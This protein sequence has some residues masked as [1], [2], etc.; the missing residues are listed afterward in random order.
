[1]QQ[2]LLVEDSMMFGRLAK[3][4]LEKVFDIPV[5]WAQSLAETEKLLAQANGNFS[6][7]LLDFNLPDAPQGE[8]IDMVVDHGISAI[9]FTTNM[10][11]EV[12]TRIWDKKVADYIIKE[13]PNSLDYVISTIRQFEMNQNTLVLIVDKSDSNRSYF[14][15]LLYVRKF[16]V[17]NASDAETAFDILQ[18]YPE[19]KLVIA[20]FETSGFDGCSFSQKIRE[21]HTQEELAI[22]GFTP[23]DD[24]M[25]GIAYIKSGASDYVITDPFIVEEFY[26]KISRTLEIVNL[27]TLLRS[28]T[29]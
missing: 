7:A 11:D 16:R 9:V 18:Q 27:H 10:S 6:V 12:R 1:M 22:V 20:D 17:L 23:F 13:D 26:T 2:M 8:V 19:I 4:R 28:T 3:K 15:E 29:A 5:F 25:R 14:S 24:R 21:K